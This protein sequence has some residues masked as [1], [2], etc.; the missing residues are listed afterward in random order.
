MIITII[1]ILFDKNVCPKECQKLVSFENRGVQ[2][3]LWSDFEIAS[4]D[5]RSLFSD[6]HSYAVLF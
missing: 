1:I 3:F 2:M 4:A 6:S 5:I